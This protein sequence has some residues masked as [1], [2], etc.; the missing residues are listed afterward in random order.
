MVRVS[1]DPSIRQGAAVVWVGKQPLGH[2]GWNLKR[3]TVYGRTQVIIQQLNNLVVEAR[4]DAVICER[5]LSRPGRNIA[6]LQT[7]TA[8]IK[9]WA[10]SKGAQWVEFSPSTWRH[11]LLK[12]RGSWDAQR[13]VWARIVRQWWALTE[14]GEHQLDAL[15]IGWAY[16]SREEAE[17]RIGAPLLVG[18]GG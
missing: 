10:I 12:Y 18:G 3:G 11:R 17:R 14:M 4:L 8:D 15:G 1:I 9:Q 16:I 7:L 2:T 6:P 5:H 13:R